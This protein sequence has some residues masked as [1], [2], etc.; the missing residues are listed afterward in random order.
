[1]K[2]VVIF[3]TLVFL[4]SIN[5]TMRAGI[6]YWEDNLIHVIDDNTHK[7]DIIFLDLNTYNNPGTHIELVEGG[8]IKGVLCRQ[9]SSIAVS[10]GEIKINFSLTN[11]STGIMTGG[12]VSEVNTS[13]YAIFD[14][15]NGTVNNDFT[16]SVHSKVTMTGGLI[17]GN[18]IARRDSTAL[19]SNGTIKKSLQSI[20]DAVITLSGG[21]IEGGIGTSENAIQYLVG[22]YFEVNGQPLSS[23]DKLSDFV[24]LTEYRVDGHVFDYYGGNIIAT[25]A[26]GSALDNEFHV[27]NTGYFEGTGDIIVIENHRP[28]AD[29]GADITAYAWIDGIAEIT[30]DGTGSYDIDGDELKY[31]WYDESNELLATGA[32]PNVLFEAG[33]YEVTLIV[34][35]GFQDSEPN[36]CM[37][38]IYEAIETDAKIT[39]QSLNRKSHRPHVIGRLELTGYSAADIDP[40]EPMVLMP[41]DIVANR[42]EILPASGEAESLK[43]VGFFD[44]A[45]L[46]EAIDQDG[47]VEVTVAVKL[48]SGQWAYGTDTVKVK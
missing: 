20:H 22:T 36:L 21:T 12:I 30:F 10:G 23:G 24:P 19:I 18:F 25:L 11:N 47:N 45:A 27:F 5:P 33:E 46:L 41:G 2:R 31:F 17:K 1:M 43:L 37:V 35:D 42:V 29:A 8:Y 6:L 16:A 3:I 7:N 34:N 13:Q 15:I 14:L 9:G 40:N 26:D 38:T 4:V 44:N 48:L 32:N 39:P 28:V